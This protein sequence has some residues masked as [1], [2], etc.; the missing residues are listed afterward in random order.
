MKTTNRKTM[1][2]NKLIAEFMGANPWR[3]YVNEDVE[4]YEMYGVLEAIHLTRISSQQFWLPSEMQFHESW[5]WIMPVVVRLFHD[6]YNEFDG[7]DDLS[8]RLNNTLLDVNLDSLYRIVVEFI[9]E[10]NKSITTL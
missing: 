10:Y 9:K 7:A 2:D 6:E 8:F 1:E 4:S 3:E 5:D